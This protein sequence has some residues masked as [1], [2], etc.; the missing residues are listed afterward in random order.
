MFSERLRVARKRKGL[1]QEELARRLG[2]TKG[3]ISNY[4]N[5]YSS[6]SLEGLAQICLILD[7]SADYLIDLI[8]HLPDKMSMQKEMFEMTKWNEVKEELDQ[9][10]ISTTEIESYNI[11]GVSAG[12]NTPAGGDSGAGGRTYVKLEDLAST[13]MRVRV[14]GNYTDEVSELEIIFGGDSEAATLIEA[15]EFT[16]KTLKQQIQENAKP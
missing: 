7:V 3:T 2:T 14:N 1:T 12:T 8:D 6:P 16:V 5:N 11:L 10:E 9:L 4:E 13:D 15:L